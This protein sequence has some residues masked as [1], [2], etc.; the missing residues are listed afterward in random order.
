MP[1]Q[2]SNAVTSSLLEITWTSR[3]N[4][5]I[6][7][8]TEAPAL[9]TDSASVVALL[10]ALNLLPRIGFFDFFVMVSHNDPSTFEGLTTAL[11]PTE[12]PIRMCA[13]VPA[14]PSSKR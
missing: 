9:Y 12:R 6:L 1:G 5:V 2:S 3:R 4:W 10:C 13:R 14:N 7:R 8:R 11:G